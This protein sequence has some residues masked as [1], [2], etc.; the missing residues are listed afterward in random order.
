MT[1]TDL[2]APLKTIGRNRRGA[3]GGFP[4][5]QEQRY[6]KRVLDYGHNVSI[7]GEGAYLGKIKER[8]IH[9]RCIRD[10]KSRRCG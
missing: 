6:L 4:I 8:Y 7:I 1:E 3:K 2:G 10:E 5:R 9:A